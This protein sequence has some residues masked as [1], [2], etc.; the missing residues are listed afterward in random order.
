MNLLIIKLGA[1]G[2]VLRM[3]SI[4]KPLKERYKDAK[5]TW[6]TKK[7]SEDL[8]RGNP[9]VDGIVLIG[10]AQKGAL[11]A[12]GIFPFSGSNHSSNTLFSGTLASL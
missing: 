1:M 5:I 3:T 4:L 12:T 11:N 6:V 2:D 8:L 7:S 9:H 10:Q